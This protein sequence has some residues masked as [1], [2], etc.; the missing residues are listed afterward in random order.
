L[1]VVLLLWALLLQVDEKNKYQLIVGF[2][3]SLLLGGLFYKFRKKMDGK[4]SRNFSL[5]EFS[6]KD[7]APTP[8]AVLDNLRKLAQNLEVIRAHFGNVPVTINSGYRSP[9]HNSKV[10]GKPRSLH[11]TGKAVDFVIKGY[12]P[13]QIAAELEKL[14]DQKKISQGGI[15]VYPNFIH[16]DIRGK[17]ARW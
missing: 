10:K 7:G 13:K 11:M 3:L 2:G 6:S 4:L 8:P 5:K 15:G 17:K 1:P 16:Y 9:A 12:S 14:I